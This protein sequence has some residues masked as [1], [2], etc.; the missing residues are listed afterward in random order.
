MPEW[1]RQPKAAI[2]YTLVPAT[3]RGEAHHTTYLNGPFVSSRSSLITTRHNITSAIKGNFLQAPCK[4]PFFH[5]TA[6]RPK[7]DRTNLTFCEIHQW[8]TLGSFRGADTVGL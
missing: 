7:K 2:P 1:E 6:V 8:N 4:V 5:S 3:S